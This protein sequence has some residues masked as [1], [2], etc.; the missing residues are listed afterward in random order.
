MSCLSAI[1]TTHEG[2][3]AVPYVSTLESPG[4]PGYSLQAIS[5]VHSIPF[6]NCGYA[7][8][9]ARE[10]HSSLYHSESR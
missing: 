5:R 8:S 10:A 4:Q 7:L 6:Q 3:R 2:E 9:S 1:Q